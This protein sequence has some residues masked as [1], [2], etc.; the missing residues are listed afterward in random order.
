MQNFAFAQVRDS[1]ELAEEYQKRIRIVSIGT[2]GL[3][4]VSMAGLYSLW[5]ADFETSPMHS[6]DDSKEWLYMDKVGH[7]LTSY[8]VGKVG[9]NTFEW[10]G[11]PRK[12]AIWIGGSVGFVFLTTVEV[13]DGFSSE[14]GFSYADMAANAL[15]AG[16]LIGQEYLWG[17]QRITMKFSYHSTEYPQYR[18][19]QLGENWQQSILKDYNGQTYWLS[20]N[21]KSLLQIPDD[22]KF[23]AWLNFSVGYGA[24]GMTGA[25]ENPPLNEEGEAIPQF[26]RRKQFYIAPDVELS[27]IPTKSRFLKGLFG[28]IGF[29]KFPAPTIEFTEGGDVRFKPLYF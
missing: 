13:F 25:N 4:V 21:I 12:K 16:F 9:I 5:Y 1:V 18:P 23:P 11:M 28:T 6:F 27:R 19:D 14:W 15:G 24:D 22:S 10:A 8:Y 29:L 20:A 7:A 2:A 3:Y 26:D 17:E